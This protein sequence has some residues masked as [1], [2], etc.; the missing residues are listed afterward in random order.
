MSFDFAIRREAKDYRV[1]KL[2]CNP[3]PA[4]PVPEESPRIFADQESA[5]EKIMQSISRS[6]SSEDRRPTHILIVGGYGNG[7]SHVLKV[8]R[9]SVLDQL[10][11]ENIAIAGYASARGWSFLNIYKGFMRDLGV[12]FF[13]ELKIKILQRTLQ[14]KEGNQSL[15]ALM[16]SMYLDRLE[17]ASKVGARKELRGFLYN[18]M[19]NL[20]MVSA[21]MNMFNSEEAFRIAYRWICGEWIDLFTLRRY[22]ITSRLDSD[23]KALAAIVNFRKL[24]EIVG[25]KMIF[26]CI[27]EFE[28]IVLFPV[29]MR[30]NFLDSIR[31]VMDWNPTGLTLIFSC[32]PEALEAIQ[33]YPPLD[34]ISLRV[35]LGDPSEEKLPLYVQAYIAASRVEECDDPLFPFSVEVIGRIFK[36]LDERNKLNI[37]NFLKLCHYAIEEGL[38]IEKER[39]DG[40]VIDRLKERRDIYLG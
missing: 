34:R 27:D 40:E 24:L 22:G 20:D 29:Q 28:K 30:V 38:D 19:T 23:E 5:K 17:P 3:F 32:S 4:S 9:T 12:D 6:I 26:I 21:F 39:I 15:T 36:L 13:E 14:T 25:F 33:R 7:K 18:S 16:D 11:P 31:H 8:V 10:F 2:R 35:V 37:R 1:Y